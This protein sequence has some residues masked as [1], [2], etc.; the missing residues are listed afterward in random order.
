MDY[1]ETMKCLLKYARKLE[2]AFKIPADSDFTSGEIFAL[3]DDYDEYVLNCYGISVKPRTHEEFKEI[4]NL[5]FNAD[6]NKLAIGNFVYY[7]TASGDLIKTRI[8]SKDIEIS[9]TVRCRID[10]INDIVTTGE[11]Y[12]TNKKWN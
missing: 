4:W 8:V 1:G 11:L 7:L 6:L 10:C 9:V 12:N 2:Y 5:I 3:L